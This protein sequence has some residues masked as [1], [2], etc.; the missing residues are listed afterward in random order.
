MAVVAFTQTVKVGAHPVALDVREEGQRDTAEP[1][2]KRKGSSRGGSDAGDH[3]I[4]SIDGRG[5]DGS[6][7]GL[8]I[9]RAVVQAREESQLGAPGCRCAPRSSTDLKMQP[10]SSPA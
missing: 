8:V 10:S 4:G 3:A 6:I 9:V 7:G 1:S 5:V 2:N